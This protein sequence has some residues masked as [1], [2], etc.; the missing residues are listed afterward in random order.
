MGISSRQESLPLACSSLTLTDPEVQKYLG[1][2]WNQLPSYVFAPVPI[3][4]VSGAPI[5]YDAGH[6]FQRGAQFHFG[7]RIGEN[8]SAAGQRHVGRANADFAH[9]QLEQ[10]LAMVETH[11]R[12]ARAWLSHLFH[13]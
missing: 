2:S 12:Q 11:M 10:L 7:D 5:H 1:V 4:V 3:L 9:Q 8:A 13:Q 6:L